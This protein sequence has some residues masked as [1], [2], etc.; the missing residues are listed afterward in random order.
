MPQLGYC[1][2]D[3]ETCLAR[4]A[5]AAGDEALLIEAAAEWLRRYGI[6]F[7][8]DEM[9]C[10][11]CGSGR[12]G[13]CCFECPVRNCCR[14]KGFATCAECPSYACESLEKIFK[15]APAARRR[16]DSLRSAG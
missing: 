8:L 14:E 13:G 4:T 3:C 12:R 10:E 9:R 2:Q 5:T 15:I 7:S 6:K 16:L 1:G 11:G